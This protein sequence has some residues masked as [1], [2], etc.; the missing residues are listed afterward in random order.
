MTQIIAA[1]CTS[2]SNIASDR[3]CEVNTATNT[4]TNIEKDKKSTNGT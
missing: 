1:N 2:K 3:S 4:Q